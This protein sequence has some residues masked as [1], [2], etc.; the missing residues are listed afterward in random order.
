[1]LIISYFYAMLLLFIAFLMITLFDMP[2]AIRRHAADCF[3]SILMPPLLIRYAITRRHTP[4][5]RCHM[6]RAY[7]AI[8][9]L[10]LPLLR[11]YAARFHY[12]PLLL[13][14]HVAATLRRCRLSRCHYYAVADYTATAHAAHAFAASP[15]FRYATLLFATYAG[16]FFSR[17]I[18]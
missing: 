17:M 4:L 2:L 6:L 9:S 7:F 16:Y 12:T 3:S 18:F 10:S 15:P 14:R 8:I 11:R 1:M 13:L 5:L